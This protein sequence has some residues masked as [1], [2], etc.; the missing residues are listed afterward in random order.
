MD[1]KNDNYAKDVEVILQNKTDEEFLINF[2]KQ[3]Y[4]FFALSVLFAAFGAYIGMDFYVKGVGLNIK[5]IIIE[6]VLIIGLWFFKSMPIVNVVL[7]FAFTFCSGLT[8]VPLLR[9]GLKAGDG[10]S[11]L[12]QAFLM[13]TIIFGI[14]SYYALK[15]TRDLGDMAKTLFISLIVIFIAAIISLILGN[16]ILVVILSAA[17]CIVFSLY[18]A[19]NTQKI[20]KGDCDSPITA[21]IDLYLDVFSVFDLILF[22]LSV[23]NIF[24]IND[25]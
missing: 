2:V 18:I 8:L 5:L 4:K 7:L 16:P 19:Y 25:E 1:L 3:T 14:M 23:R 24:R 11:L 22:F 10:A 9:L 20:I 12:I 21:A 6:I 13:T 17:L 15:T